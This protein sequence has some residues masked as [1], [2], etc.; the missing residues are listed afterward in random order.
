MARVGRGRAFGRRRLIGAGAAG[1]AAILVACGGQGKR[2]EQGESGGAGQTIATPTAE[3]GKPKPGGSLTTRINGN[4][5]LDLVANSNFRSATL[6][7]YVYSRLLKVRTDNDPNTANKL[8]FVPDLV[9]AQPEITDGGLTYIFKLRPN[10]K[11]HNV[12]PLSGRTVTSEDIVATVERFR[13]EPK[14]QN[15]GIFQAPQAVIDKMEAP[16]PQTV[17]FKLSRKYASF[18]SLFANSYYVYIQPREVNEGKVDPS[19][20]AIGSGPFILESFQP[21]ISFKLKKNPEYFLTGQPYVDAAELAIMIEDVQEVAQLQAGKLDVSTTVPGFP[22]DQVAE[23][24]RTTPKATVVEYLDGLHDYIAM[25]QRGDSPFR[26]ERVRRALTM[27]VDK[28]ALLDLRFQGKGVWHSA[29]AAWHSRYWLD[30]Q[31]AEAGPAAQWVKYNPREARALLRAAGQEGLRFNWIY[32]NNAGY[33]ERFNQAAEAI[34][35]MLKD[36]G[37]SPQIQT[38]DYQREYIVPGGVVS[39]NFQ[40][41]FYGLNTRYSDP[42]EYLFTANYSKSTRNPA[43]VNDPQLDALI[44]KEAEELDLAKRIE[45]IKDAQRYIMDKAYYGYGAVGNGFVM[46]QP[47]A[48]NYT[49]NAAYGQGAEMAANLWIDKS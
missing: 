37:F 46:V 16:D 49:R 22:A 45:L 35:G 48:K 12:A 5:P 28:Q 33:G 18:L 34:A 21:D 8:E 27:S 29:V 40:G 31:S 10:A 44:D 14:N 39:G 17:V 2:E 11:W 15:R 32:S 25:Q 20:Q 38:S 7:S 1:A 19:K 24:R 9:A 42:H 13:T 23:F 36:A 43:G 30:P 26:D 47:W 6:A 4:A 41:A 3:T